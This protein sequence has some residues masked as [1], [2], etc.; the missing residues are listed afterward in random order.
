[1]CTM[2]EECRLYGDPDPAAPRLQRKRRG[3]VVHHVAVG[4][5]R[6]PSPASGG[7]R[8]LFAVKRGEK[9]NMYAVGFRAPSGAVVMREVIRAF[10]PS[11]SFFS[12][13]CHKKPFSDCFNFPMHGLRFPI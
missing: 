5:G 3:S 10:P 13:K 4:S 11:L 7:K 12:A 2:Y 1:M 9:H 6:K 8:M